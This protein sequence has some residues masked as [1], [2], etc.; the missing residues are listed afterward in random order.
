MDVLSLLRTGD[1]DQNVAIEIFRDQLEVVRKR[2][3]NLAFIENEDV[4]RVSDE[5]VQLLLDYLHCWYTSQGTFQGRES[6]YQKRYMSRVYS[7]IRALKEIQKLPNTRAFFAET[8]RVSGNITIRTQVN[9]QPLQPPPSFLQSSVQDWLQKSGD[10]APEQPRLH[11][12]GTPRSMMSPAPSV[13]QTNRIYDENKK[14]SETL[15]NENKG[16]KDVIVKMGEEIRSL[17]AEV[18]AIKENEKSN[19]R[20]LQAAMQDCANSFHKLERLDSEC[21]VIES[22]YKQDLDLKDAAIQ[23][24]QKKNSELLNS[25]ELFQLKYQKLQE[26][27]KPLKI[28]NEYLMRNLGALEEKNRALN[29]LLSN[30]EELEK[31]CEASKKEI[32]ELTE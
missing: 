8:T 7:M 21:S 12:Q 18:F 26:E 30:Q 24:L 19:A 27:M 20:D 13:N 9:E 17:K 28:H 15:E 23:S 11:R 22:R 5:T 1:E 6:D 31:S 2:L 3:E 29:A 10:Y 14:K 32:V 25:Q 16:L 4:A